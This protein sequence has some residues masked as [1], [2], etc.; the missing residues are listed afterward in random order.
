MALQEMG[1]GLNPEMLPRMAAF[2]QNQNDPQFKAE[3][4]LSLA[5]SGWLL[6]SDAAS[7]D[8]PLTVSA[9]RLRGLMQKYLT[10]TVPLKRDPLMQRILSELAA[11]PDVLA[12]LAAHMAPPYPLP[13]SIDKNLPGYSKLDIGLIPGQPDATYYVQLPPEY[14]PQRRYPMIVS[15]HGI[16]YDPAMQIEWWAGEHRPKTPP[17]RQGQAEDTDTSLSRRPGRS[18]IRRS[19]SFQ[20]AST[21]SCWAASA[22]PAGGLPSIATACFSPATWRAATR[23]GTS[24]YR[25]PICGRE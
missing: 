2:L 15:L 11:K 14:N 21:P 16:G 9:W 10:E 12:A 3:D 7:T 22:T 17:G 4:K 1:P 19:M 6:G 24:A 13:E 23:P 25:I 8:L 18:S 5:V 20:P